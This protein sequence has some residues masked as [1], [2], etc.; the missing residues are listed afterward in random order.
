MNHRPLRVA[1]LIEHELG[2]ILLREV[3][4]PG[5]ILTITSVEVSAKL[6]RALVMIS[7]IP[8]EHEEKSIQEANRRRREL[9][10]ML[11]NRIN[12]R[13]MPE[14]IFKIDRGSAHAARVE[15]LLLEDNTGDGA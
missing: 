13:P 7:V 12:I 6:D 4:V 2:K 1:A 10:H 8:A 11:A 3:E 15:K 14:V 5:A 9:Q